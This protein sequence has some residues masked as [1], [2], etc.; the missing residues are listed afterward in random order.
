MVDD[1]YRSPG[2][3]IGGAALIAGPLVW[4]RPSR[5][6]AACWSSSAC[7]PGRFTPAS[8]IWPSNWSRRWV[9]SRQPPSSAGML[10]L[11]IG[12]LKGSSWVSVAALVGLAIAFVPLGFRLLAEGPRPRPLVAAAWAV[13]VPALI[14][15]AYVLGRMG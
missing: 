4:R 14:V 7:S 1:G 11:M 8:T 12:V 2:R 13:F 15:L 5:H 6:G 9:W 10:T 3:W